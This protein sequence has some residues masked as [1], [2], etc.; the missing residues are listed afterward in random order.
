MWR[1]YGAQL[2]FGAGAGAVVVARRGGGGIPGPAAH[3]IMVRIADVDAHCA[4]A[5]AAG[6]R[7]VQ[8][9][10][11]FPYGERQYTVIDP[12]GHVWTFSQTLADVDPQEWGGVL[13]E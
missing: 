13:V 9:P 2:T 6:A 3:S 11:D 5:T 10:T 1:E 12:G 7:L 4:L 8:P